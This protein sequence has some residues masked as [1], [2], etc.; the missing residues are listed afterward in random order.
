MKR[1]ARRICGS[2]DSRV[3]V[4]PYCGRMDQPLPDY[5]HFASCRLCDRLRCA[6]VE[7]DALG[8]PR[9]MVQ[10]IEEAADRL[11]RDART[12]LEGARLP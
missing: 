12:P 11:E 8:L 6:A 5:P 3:T 1:V 2:V 10:A 9:L 7:A 4:R